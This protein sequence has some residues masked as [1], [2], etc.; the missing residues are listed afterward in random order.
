MF[1]VRARP[2]AGIACLVARPG[3]RVLRPFEGSIREWIVARVAVMGGRAGRRRRDDWSGRGSGVAVGRGDGGT[4]G[5]DLDR[6]G[7]PAQTRL[8]YTLRDVQYD[9]LNI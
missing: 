3:L 7:L 9:V 4:N 2:F 8:S 6:T 5:C 1:R